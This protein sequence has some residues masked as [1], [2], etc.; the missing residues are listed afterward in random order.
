[1]LLPAHPCPR[2]L[3]ALSIL[4]LRSSILAPASGI[5][6]VPPTIVFIPK[7][8][9]RTRK[10]RE[11]DSLFWQTFVPPFPQPSA[12]T[13][14]AAI[15]LKII[16]K[17]HFFRLRSPQIRVQEPSAATLPPHDLRS[18]FDYRAIR[19]TPVPSLRAFVPACLR[20]F[21]QKRS[22]HQRNKTP[23]AFCDSPF[24][25]SPRTFF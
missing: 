16:S 4:D 8:S 19:A 6:L 1:M 23:P 13:R 9:F 12:R 15:A 18:I 11:K 20:S 21:L 25:L 22:H 5:A 10:G 14:V 7:A 3:R 24:R 17:Q 2:P